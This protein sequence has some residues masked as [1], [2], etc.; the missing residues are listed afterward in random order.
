MQ[1]RLLLA[2]AIAALLCGTLAGCERNTSVTGT[3]FSGGV[4]G[5]PRTQLI[6][7][8]MTGGVA[9]TDMRVVIHPDGE[10]ITTSNHNP[11]RRFEIADGKLEKVRSLLE[12]GRW[13]DAVPV[14]D[15]V[16]VADGFHYEI[17]YRGRHVTAS[18]P[19]VPAWMAEIAA[20]MNALA[21]PDR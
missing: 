1:K 19:N 10:V 15:D 14:P 21:W 12:D 3:G 9:G 2:L 18:D 17:T 6:V 20:A 7:Y 16:V 13:D 5:E 8:R 4:T 11:T